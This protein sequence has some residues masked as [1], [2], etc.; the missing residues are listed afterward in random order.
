MSQV[1]N[2]CGMG[3]TGMKITVIGAVLTV[4]AIIAGLMLLNMILNQ[5]RSG[6]GSEGVDPQ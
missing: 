6:S 4:A 2:N 1:R 5:N 3:A